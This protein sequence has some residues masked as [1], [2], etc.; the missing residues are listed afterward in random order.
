M[1]FKSVMRWDPQDRKFRVGRLLW[2]RGKVGFGGYSAKFSLALT[3]NLLRVQ[4]G[5]NEWRFGILG[6]E[7]HVKKA[8]GGLIV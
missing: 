5:L 3:P 7:F 6:V 2:Q 8:W 1:K 4:R